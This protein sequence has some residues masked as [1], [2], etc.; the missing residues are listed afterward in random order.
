MATKLKFPQG[1]ARSYLLHF[2]RPDGDPEDLTGATFAAYLKRSVFDADADA[3][4]DI[5][6]R[7]AALDAAGGDAVLSF[8]PA[9]TV[10]LDP[11]LSCEFQVRATLADGRVLALEA[12][13]GPLV[14]AP[15]VGD[16]DIAEPVAGGTYIEE[17]S[18]G[19]AGG[20]TA[21][22]SALGSTTLAAA[23]ETKAITFATAFASAPRVVLVQ[24]VAPSDG[25]VISHSVD[26]SP[27]TT[28]FTVRFGAP[29]PASG[30]KLTWA[31]FA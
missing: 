1:A 23:D 3:L 12:H 21:A 30:Y 15:L 27:T 16:P 17:Y 26:A 20:G 29:I 31:A 11:F 19:T 14:F 13:Q 8:F 4:E 9:D 18:V 10:D 22:A 2:L 28:G 7:V 25:F 5:S 6:A 24:L